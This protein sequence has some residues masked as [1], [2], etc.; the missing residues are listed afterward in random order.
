MLQLAEERRRADELE[1]EG[2]RQ[3]RVLSKEVRAL[4]AQLQSAHTDN[5]RMAAKL[6]TLRSII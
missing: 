1:K 4:R 5:A 6:D 3:R 2:R